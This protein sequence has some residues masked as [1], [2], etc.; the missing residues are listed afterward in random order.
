[1]MK[2]QRR[3]LLVGSAATFLVPL[4]MAF[5]AFGA[6]HK[7]SD[8]ATSVTLGEKM[9]LANGKTLPAGTYRVEMPADSQTPV[10]RFSQDGKVV[11]T[12]NAKVVSEGN[13]NPYT[14]IDSVKQGDAT[15]I[16][17]IRPAGWHEILKFNTAN[18]GGAAGGAQ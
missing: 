14:E 9:E 13:K 6:S 7:A 11:A 2:I 8:R 3:R 10:V 5:V 1:M 4:C 17:T 12:A 18:Q 15:E 16:T